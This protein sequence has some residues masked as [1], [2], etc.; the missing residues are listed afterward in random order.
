VG[1]EVPNI[2]SSIVYLKDVLSCDEFVKFGSKLALA[3]GK[4]TA[5]KSLIADL[6]GMPHLLIAGTTGSGKTVCVNSIVMSI[7]YS[8]TPQEVKFV[9]IDPKMVELAT[10][11]ACRIYY[12]R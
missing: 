6:D 5:G 2:Q 10:L 8:A 11:T 7:L 9:M 1:V 4:D 12:V 3:L